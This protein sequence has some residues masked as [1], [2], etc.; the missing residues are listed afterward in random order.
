MINSIYIR[1]SSDNIP[2]FEKWVF[3]RVWGDGQGGREKAVTK[4][5]HE[6]FMVMELVSIWT[7]M[8]ET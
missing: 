3:S 5:Q 6:R 7:G 8:V 2:K 4:K 1:F